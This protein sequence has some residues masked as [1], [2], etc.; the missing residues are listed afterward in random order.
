MPSSSRIEDNNVRL[1]FPEGWEVKNLPATQE[2]QETYVPSWV[3]K[4]PWRRKWQ[5]TLI[6][7]SEEFRGQRS[8]VGYN[9]WSCQESKRFEQPSTHVCTWSPGTNRLTFVFYVC[10]PMVFWLWQSWKRHLCLPRATLIHSSFLGRCT[11]RQWQE[12]SWRF[13]FWTSMSIFD[14]MWIGAESRALYSWFPN[15]R[16]Q[17]NF[18]WPAIKK[19]KKLYSRGKNQTHQSGLCTRR[20]SVASYTCLLDEEVKC[21]S[22]C[23]TVLFWPHQV[24]CG[25]LI[26]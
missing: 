17:P 3:G 7:L 19:K 26:P 13:L 2:T 15:C 24:A 6:F 20:V 10:A 16:N 22:N 12:V 14:P 9:P 1:G 11:R 8:L 5:P 25:I 23:E 21:I 4:I 18:L